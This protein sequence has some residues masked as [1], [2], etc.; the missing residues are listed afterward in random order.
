V[1]IAGLG[2]Q[3][4]FGGH[5]HNDNALAVLRDIPGLL[6][7]CPSNGADAVGLLQEALR[8]ADEEQ[9]VVVLLEPIALYHQRDLH[10]PDDG[11]W[12]RSDPGPDHRLARGEPGVHGDGCDLAIL[13]YGNGAY[14][15]LQAQP[16]LARRSV[17]SRI[18]D[19]RWLTA[20]DHDRVFAA[21]RDCARVLIV[22]ECRRS[23]SVSEELMAELC[24]RGLDGSRLRR[25]TAEDSFI[26][27]GVA[28]TST[29]PSRDRIVTEAVALV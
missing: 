7:A 3:K 22:D 19:L 9:R 29:L 13:S 17:H 6:L 1:R 28:A 8:L 25:L 23:G 15:A 27:L 12:C 10:A 18:V 5:F 24:V 2:Y 26:P 14:L 11:L 21:V 4:G 20:I 16:E